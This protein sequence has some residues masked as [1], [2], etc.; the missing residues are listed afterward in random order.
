MVQELLV[1][2]L[3]S[4]L[5]HKMLKLEKCYPSHSPAPKLFTSKPRAKRNE[6]TCFPSKVDRS[7]V[8]PTVS[9]SAF[10][11]LD[12]V[13]LS[14]LNPQVNIYT[15]FQLSGLFIKLN[16]GGSWKGK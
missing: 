6:M 10:L 1:L 11:R 14:L 15:V 16:L 7:R 12:I 9:L 5:S 2:A 4:S 13:H 8:I 3:C